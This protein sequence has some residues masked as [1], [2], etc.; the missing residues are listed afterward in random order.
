MWILKSRRD[1]KTLLPR[2]LPV[3]ILISEP[4]YMRKG[5]CLGDR[6]HPLPRPQQPTSWS[7]CFEEDRNGQRFFVVACERKAPY[8]HS[9]TPPPSRFWVDVW[10][11]EI[12]G[13]WL[14]DW[15]LCFVKFRW[16]LGECR[17]VGLDFGAA[18][19]AW[20]GFPSLRPR[21]LSRWRGRR[22]RWGYEDVKKEEWEGFDHFKIGVV[23]TLK[24]NW[25]IHPSVF[26]LNTPI[27][28]KKTPTLWA[29]NDF[30]RECTK[31]IQKFPS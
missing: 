12:L 21:S 23:H 8:P 28:L 25:K 27:F 5:G 18:V 17:V 10:L 30:W 22:G 1:N 19:R 26:N 4:T 20:A 9:L 24:S 7:G 14:N 3:V 2:I 15:K 31:S 13:I 16:I 6:P 11:R 29:Q